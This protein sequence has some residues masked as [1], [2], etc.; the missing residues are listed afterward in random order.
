MCVISVLHGHRPRGRYIISENALCLFSGGHGGTCP[1]HART[2]AEALATPHPPL[3]EEGGT[4]AEAAAPG[5]AT[6]GP[7]RL[8][9][10]WGR[11]GPAPACS[12][13]MDCSPDSVCSPSS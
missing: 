9:L 13:Q 3:L 10:P 11:I 2:W 12:L 5:A 4:F 6:L 7:A 8:A 1:Q